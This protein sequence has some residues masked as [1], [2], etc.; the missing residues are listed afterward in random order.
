[1][2]SKITVIHGKG[3][4][5]KKEFLKEKA[6]AA[7]AR[8]FTIYQLNMNEGQAMFEELLDEEDVFIIDQ[9]SGNVEEWKFVIDRI[10]ESK[11]IAYIATNTTPPRFIYGLGDTTIINTNAAVQ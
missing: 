8:V 3:S 6:I 10:L 2:Q 9:F 11:S 7:K 4:T 5:D 1:M